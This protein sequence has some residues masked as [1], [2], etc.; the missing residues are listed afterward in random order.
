MYLLDRFVYQFR[1]LIKVKTGGGKALHPF[2][3]K[4]TQ[5]QA[6]NFSFEE[7]KKIYQK[8]LEIDLD[9][10]TGRINARTALELFVTKL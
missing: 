1:N 9:I 5:S 6:S 3:F 2:V 10:K 4:K 7:L 8:L